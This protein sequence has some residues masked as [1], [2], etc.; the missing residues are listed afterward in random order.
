MRV[1]PLLLLLS[2]GISP[3]ANATDLSFY[4]SD[5]FPRLSYSVS[6]D[7]ATASPIFFLKGV[8]IDNDSK[9]AEGVN[10]TIINFVLL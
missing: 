3:S 1:S 2:L 6:S 5:I 10:I 8:C 9:P 7:T 4:G